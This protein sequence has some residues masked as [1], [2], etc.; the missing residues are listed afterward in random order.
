MV[1]SI[2]AEPNQPLNQS[3]QYLVDIDFQSF[4]TKAFTFLV[5]YAFHVLNSIRGVF[6]VPSFFI[7]VVTYHFRYYR[8]INTHLQVLT[9][10]FVFVLIQYF[11]ICTELFYSVT[12][13]RVFFLAIMNDVQTAALVPSGV[14][15]PTAAAAMPQKPTEGAITSTATTQPRM[16]R[17]STSSRSSRSTSS[18]DRNRSPSPYRRRLRGRRSRYVRLLLA[19][20]A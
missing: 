15:P 11:G 7:F 13:Y 2:P 8:A 17:R 12:H 9:S 4:P 20:C 3:Q 5:P 16:R 19:Y 1:L 6:Q 18:R 14:P 10:L